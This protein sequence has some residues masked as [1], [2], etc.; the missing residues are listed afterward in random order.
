MK[1]LT[2]RELNR[3]TASVL[4]AVERGETFELQRNGKAI[5]YLTHTAP[6]PER[7]P[8]WG[9]HLDWLKRQPKSRGRSLIAEFEEDRR[10]LRSREKAMGNAQ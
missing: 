3:K 7:K 2:M 5:G 1:A 6:P 4:D 9:A 10:R 8:D